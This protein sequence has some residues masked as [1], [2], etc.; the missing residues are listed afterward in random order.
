MR[1]I[2][3]ALAAAA[4]HALLLGVFVAGFGG[5]PSALTCTGAIRAGRFPYEHV[6]HSFG[7]Y[8]YDGQFYYALARAPFARHTEGFQSDAPAKRQLRLFYPLVSWAL[9]GGDHP[10][11]L[12]WML[13]AVNLVAVAGLA[14]LGALVA[15]RHGFSPWWGVLLPLAVNAGMAALR[16]L[17]DVVSTFMLGALLVGWLFRVP[18]WLLALC[19]AAAVFSREQNAA[20][21]AVVFACAAWER[22]WLT[23][24]GLAAALALW[25]GWVLWLAHVYQASP[26]LSASEG[27]FSLVPFYGWYHAWTHLGPD[28]K[29]G[30]R[31]V[32]CLLLL[33]FQTGL[34]LDLLRRR[35]VAPAI[36]LA[37]LVG[38]GLMLVGGAAIY[39]DVWSFG[40]VFAP[41]PLAVWLGCVQA[42]RL[43]ALPP[44]SAYLLVQ[45]GTVA[46]EVAVRA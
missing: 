13:P 40:R 37:L 2:P 6:H 31:T 27:N 42:R 16:D 14:W 25:F 33:A 9:A 35:E 30:L 41:L 26:F 43:W 8:G 22:R 38:L 24:A 5:D 10:E 32:L 46:A 39:E 4:M 19:G 28:V 34:A 12:L 36:R 20:G 21:L 11:L 17:T 23:C 15:A 18:W 7:E 45:W 44:L 29:H 1:L 3:P